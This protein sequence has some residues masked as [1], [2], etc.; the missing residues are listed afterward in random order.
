M[1]GGIKISP[2]ANPGRL[3]C[4]RRKARLIQGER[5]LALFPLNSLLAFIY[6]GKIDNET[7]PPLPHLKKWS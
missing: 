2:S 6:A 4:N 1:S 7:A 3:P 5:R